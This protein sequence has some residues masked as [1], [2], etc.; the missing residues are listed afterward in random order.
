[1]EM[2]GSYTVEASLLMPVILGAIVVL[3]YMSFFLH[4][5][6]IL[7]EGAAILANQYTNERNL[8][9]DEIKQRLQARS[10]DVMNGNVI[11][12]KNITTEITV[13]R[14]EIKVECKGDFFFPSLYVV[15]AVFQGRD[16]HFS[17]TK[18]MKRYDPVQ[19][20][21]NCRKVERL[22]R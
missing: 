4:D 6:A 10:N 2:K 20:I 16:F 14:K 18:Q 9:N 8:T 19:F 11:C 13:S 21:R 1:M 12:T 5:R 22:L 17:V 15:Q 3:I 7:Y